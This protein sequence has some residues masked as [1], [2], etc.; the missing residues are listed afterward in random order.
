M[1]RSNLIRTLL[2][3]VMTCLVVPICSMIVGHRFDM[4]LDSRLIRLYT[5][6]FY[7]Q[8]LEFEFSLLKFSQVFLSEIST[9]KHD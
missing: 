3:L 4:I 1:A 5:F 9:I 7:I 6:K 8:I 2:G